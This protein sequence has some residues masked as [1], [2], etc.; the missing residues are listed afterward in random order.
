M[1]K[2]TFGWAFMNHRTYHAHNE[3]GASLIE[4]LV[5][6]AIVGIMSVAIFSFIKTSYDNYVTSY[7]ISQQ[8]Q[9]SLI[10]KAALDNT[11]SNAGSIAPPYL[12]STGSET[13]NGTTPFNFLGALTTFLYG[14]CPSSGIFGNIFSFLNNTGNN[15]ID[16]LFFGGYNAAHTTETDGSSNLTT[17]SL[18]SQPLQV[19]AQT[20]SFS[21]LVVHSS[22]GDELCN[23]TLSIVGNQMIYQ[24]TGSAN[25]HSECG[26]PEYQNTAKTDFP[27]G[28]GWTFSGPVADAHCLG[29]AFAN[30][31]PD[32]IIATDNNSHTAATKVMVCLPAM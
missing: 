19:T 12:S 29:A 17:V 31:M 28:N 26:S 13:T 21:W 20:V 9:K 30:T 23:G 2:S 6:L 16:N 18:P 4:L 25:S 10:M 15:L 27:V 8:I 5:S 7:Q 11:V 22:G 3:Y 14:N 1:D 32:A 24:V